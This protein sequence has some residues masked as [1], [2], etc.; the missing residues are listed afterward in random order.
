MKACWR[1]TV[2]WKGARLLTYIALVLSLLLAH[3]LAD[4]PFQTTKL[5]N[6]KF[7]NKPDER[8]W[9]LQLHILIHFL[10]G[11]FAIIHYV[12]TPFLLVFLVII[13][14]THYLTDKM[15]T[16]FEKDSLVSFFF[17]QLLH[18]AVIMLLVITLKQKL[19]PAPWLN[20][21]IHQLE[22]LAGTGAFIQILVVFN[23]LVVGIWGTGI[24]IRIYIKKLRG[25]QIVDAGA[26]DGGY[27]IGL[28]ERLLVI[29]AVAT[30]NASWAGLILG[31]KSAARFRK[32][33]DDAFVE[34]FLIGSFISI[35][36]AFFIGFIIQRYLIFI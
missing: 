19:I 31:V 20:P 34:Y 22:S 15:K 33:K 14:A 9:G 3:L 25:S 11:F 28:L 21:F 29:T 7:S 18:V 5:C 8:E 17:D 26:P 36:V 16:R 4:F 32:F 30:N 24:F 6:M 2:S 1:T 35:F 12:W 27:I 10:T 23:L 13:S